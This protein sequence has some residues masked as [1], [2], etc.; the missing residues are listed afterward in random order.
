LKHFSTATSHRMI[1]FWRAKLKK[2]MVIV[3]LLYLF[4][5]CFLCKC[6]VFQKVYWRKKLISN[7]IESEWVIFRFYYKIII[8]L[9]FKMLIFGL[10]FVLHFLKL[11]ANIIVFLYMYKNHTFMQVQLGTYPGFFG[12]DSGVVWS[13]DSTKIKCPRAVAKYQITCFH[14]CYAK[15]TRD[16]KILGRN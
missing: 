2:Q 8:I 10:C 15:S 5:I 3:W 12:K 4:L 13:R 14:R 1:N 16:V 6:E 9:G 7:I 11:S